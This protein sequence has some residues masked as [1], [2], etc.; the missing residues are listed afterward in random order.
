MKTS[1]FTDLGS[2]FRNPVK[3]EQTS[4]K[5]EWLKVGQSY[6]LLAIGALFA[7][8]IASVTITYLS[9]N[10]ENAIEGLFDGQTSWQDIALMAIVIGPVLEELAFRLLLRFSRITLAFGIPIYLGFLGLFFGQSLTMQYGTLLILISFLLLIGF[11]LIKDF[12]R[13]HTQYTKLYPTL[14]YATVLTFGFAHLT[15]FSNPI[16]LI[17]L[18]PLINLPQLWAGALFTYVRV[19]FGFLFTTAFHMIYN[20]I[21]V[22]PILTLYAFGIDINTDISQE[23]LESMLDT[24]EIIALSGLTILGSLFALAVLAL[25]IYSIIEWAKHRPQK[26]KK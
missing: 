22:S 20:A 26:T 7:G 5:I 2:F 10:S 6:A 17:W 1:F 9:P 14:I 12:S 13:F 19:K 8:I 23:S 15:N 18:A 3:F 25:N 24:N 16:D 4:P 11:S 21:A